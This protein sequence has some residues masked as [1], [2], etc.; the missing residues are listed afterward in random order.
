MQT[1]ISDRKRFEAN[2]W[3]LQSIKATIAELTDAHR[4][5][6]QTTAQLSE[7]LQEALAKSYVHLGLTDNQEKFLTDLVQS[8]MEE[9]ASIFNQGDRTQELLSGLMS[10]LEEGAGS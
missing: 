1:A 10:E 4:Q 7:E 3:A 2:Q 6:T 5:Q 8:H 9:L